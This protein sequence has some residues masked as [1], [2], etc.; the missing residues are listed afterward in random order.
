MGDRI[1][2]TNTGHGHVWKRPDGARARCGGPRMC[3]EC[4]RDLALVHAYEE[5]VADRRSDALVELAEW[6]V[7]LDDVDG[8]GSD[9]R[10]TVTLTQII[11]RARAALGGE[12]RA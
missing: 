4:E 8:P 3:K 9:A 11:N 12:R 5:K 6:L 2:G 7:S 1:P 10:R